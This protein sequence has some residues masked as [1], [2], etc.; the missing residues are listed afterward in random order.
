MTNLHPGTLLMPLKKGSLNWTLIPG[1]VLWHDY[2]D[3]S[4]LTH[5]NGS[6]SLALDKSGFGNNGTQGTG[7][8]QPITGVATSNGKNLIAFDGSNDALSV[9][10]SASINNIWDG[11]GTIFFVYTVSSFG[12]RLLDKRGASQ[13][14][15]SYY[16]TAALG[17]DAK[18]LLQQDGTTQYGYLS[19]NREASI[20]I[21]NITALTWNSA[22]PAAPTVFYPNTTTAQTG[23][24]LNTGSGATVSDAARALFIGNRNDLARAAEINVGEIIVYDRTLATAEIN[25]VYSYLNNK[26]SI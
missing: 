26:W 2:A 12:G 3:T 1:K 13:S 7:S 21:T 24:V 23:D 19:P 15:W 10:A 20:G 16:H 25:Q 9:P 17:N 18:L 22:A 11:G 14:G 4:T 6:V 5:T 8:S